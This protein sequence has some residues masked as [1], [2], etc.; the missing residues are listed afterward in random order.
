[1][2]GVVILNTFEETVYTWGWTTWC[3][4]FLALTGLAALCGM[5]FASWN[6][7]AAK[8]SQGRFRTKKP[9]SGLCIFCLTLCVLFGG[10]TLYCARCGT[11]KN[12]PTYQ[13][14]LE[15]GVK[16]SEFREHYKIIEEQGITYIVQDR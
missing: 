6:H 14:L 13:V 9:F 15:D 5:V 8:E 1:M 11:V 7:K 16:I 2:D 12:V 10:I 4:I 3:T